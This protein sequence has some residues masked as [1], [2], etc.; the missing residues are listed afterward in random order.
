LRPGSR[1]SSPAVLFWV[2]SAAFIVLGA[3]TVM[4]IFGLIKSELAFRAFAIGNFVTGAMALI[5]M[6][7]M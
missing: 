7:S 3:L 1:V 4:A 2:F 6:S 5:F